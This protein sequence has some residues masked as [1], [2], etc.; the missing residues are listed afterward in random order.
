MTRDT[1][2]NFDIYSLKVTGTALTSLER[3]ANNLME[4]ESTRCSGADVVA[5]NVPWNCNG[6]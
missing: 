1:T 6:K 4:T 2:R 3:T 5:E